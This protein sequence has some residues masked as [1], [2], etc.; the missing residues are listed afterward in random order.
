MEVVDGRIKR[1]HSEDPIIASC[2]WWIDWLPGSVTGRALHDTTGVP[3]DVRSV[4]DWGA[5][6]QMMKKQGKHWT[7]KR[8]IQATVTLPSTAAGQS[9]KSENAKTQL[10]SVSCEHLNSGAL[11]KSTLVQNNSELPKQQCLHTPTPTQQ[12][13]SSSSKPAAR[14]KRSLNSGYSTEA[15][16]TRK[17]RRTDVSKIE[18]TVSM[19]GHAE[20][21]GVS[22]IE[23]LKKI[24]D[25]YLFIDFMR[26]TCDASAMQIMGKRLSTSD[27]RLRNEIFSTCSQRWQQ[28][29]PVEK[30]LY[31]DQLN[32]LESQSCGVITG[33]QERSYGS[34]DNRLDPTDGSPDALFTPSSAFTAFAPS[35]HCTLKPAP[36]SR[37]I[38]DFNPL[39]AP[40]LSPV[41]IRYMPCPLY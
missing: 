28:M 13:D 25:T 22:Y 10:K 35:L 18:P 23:A 38:S 29:S 30:H 26:T 11:Q 15:N 32:A 31:K 24:D 4:I 37:I 17:L 16:E 27:E 40:L 2:R 21:M 19:I 41:P 14:S 1:K 39:P 20:R 3:Q 8:G 34:E 33:D 9:G 7:P 6:Q 5:P 36:L 12:S